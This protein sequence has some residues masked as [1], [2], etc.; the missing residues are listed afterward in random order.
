MLS[1]WFLKIVSDLCAKLNKRIYFY[2]SKLLQKFDDILFIF[3]LKNYASYK[4]YG[5]T[6]SKYNNIVKRKNYNDL[7]TYFPAELLGKSWNK[8]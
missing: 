5:K 6:N 3:S 7:N 2:W 4:M 1:S 8:K